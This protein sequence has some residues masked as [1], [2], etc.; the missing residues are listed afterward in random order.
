MHHLGRLPPPGCESEQQ[1]A[2]A[3]A[4]CREHERVQDIRLRD[5]G[6]APA[7]DAPRRPLRL[8]RVGAGFPTAWPRL[9]ISVLG[10]AVAGSVSLT[11]SAQTTSAR[12][13]APRLS[14]SSRSSVTVVPR[15]TLPQPS[16]DSLRRR[17]RRAGGVPPRGRGRRAHQ[18]HCGGPRRPGQGAG[19]PARRVPGEGRRRDRPYGRIRPAATPGRKRLTRPI[20]RPRQAA[21][22]LAQENVRKAIAARVAAAN[23]ARAAE[24]QATTD[25]HH[26]RPA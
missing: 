26:H 1:F 3:P 9:G 25:H 10:L 18:P 2:H 4:R 20:W 23:A 14:T 15:S 8:T 24:A 21:A 17:C 12:P 22:A 7:F 13:A 16:A 5:E 11:T 6:E 19:G